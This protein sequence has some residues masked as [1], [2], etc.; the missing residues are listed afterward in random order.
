MKLKQNIGRE[1][2]SSK[3]F[4]TI[5]LIFFVPSL[6]GASPTITLPT[7]ATPGSGLSMQ[8]SGTNV[9]NGKLTALP[10]PCDSNSFYTHEKIPSNQDLKINAN[11]NFSFLRNCNEFKWGKRGQPD[12]VITKK[13][14]EYKKLGAPIDTNDQGVFFD[15][16]REVRNTIQVNYESGMQAST[17]GDVNLDPKLRGITTGIAGATNTKGY[18]FGHPVCNPY[19]GDFNQRNGA[20]M[21]EGVPDSA[22][23][24]PLIH[25]MK[26]YQNAMNEEKNDLA[27]LETLLMTGQAGQ[28]YAQKYTQMIS[29]LKALGGSVDPNNSNQLN[30]LQGVCKNIIAVET[31]YRNLLNQMISANSKK[32]NLILLQT[33]DSV[34]IGWNGKGELPAASCVG[35]TETREC[36]KE[37]HKAQVLSGCNA[38]ISDA[39]IVK[40]QGCYGG[41]CILVYTD[42]LKNYFEK[43]LE[44]INSFKGSGAQGA[45]VADG[46]GKSL[47]AYKDYFE[48]H[49][50]T[51]V[52][53][54]G[55]S[56]GK[57]V[58]LSVSTHHV[59]KKFIG[60]VNVDKINIR[61]SILVRVPEGEP[62]PS[63]PGLLEV[64]SRESAYLRGAWIQAV[65]Y[66][67]RQVESEILNQKKINISVEACSKMF[68]Y[69]NQSL[70]KVKSLDPVSVAQRISLAIN[71][72]ARADKSVQ[73]GLSA[74]MN[75]PEIWQCKGKEAQDK[76]GKPDSPKP[77]QSAL[78][79]CAV[80]S[81]LEAMFK[82]LAI[83]EIMGRAS[84]DYK[85]YVKSIAA[86]SATQHQL[87]G[88][89]GQISKRCESICNARCGGAGSCGAADACIG[90]GVDNPNGCVTQCYEMQLFMYFLDTI[91]QK[92]PLKKGGA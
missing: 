62:D 78:F 56:C 47:D 32:L 48:T 31:K 1:F 3:S 80:R 49:S 19:P 34:N 61:P 51:N 15:V 43:R 22:P 75:L 14:E 39:S 29:I 83:C 35:E 79:M 21:Q 33:W 76:F 85:N 11:T 5:S 36:D 26:A 2:Q 4:F 17:C 7:G 42:V 72:D 88:L 77:L 8:V 59:K 44:K 24:Q 54:L 46:M 87:P 6:M 89:V 73:T 16:E 18:Y 91:S 60:C 64:G 57:P 45:S 28:S 10:I 53:H 23:I 40:S 65:N 63:D 90:L 55:R 82:K 9:L 66:Y 70:E 41:K 12:T 86:G 50:G 84:A 52:N 68:E 81:N 25:D 67:W 38:I 37:E 69:N 92:W 27:T 71:Y 30:G 20:P 13:E 58:S 74:Q